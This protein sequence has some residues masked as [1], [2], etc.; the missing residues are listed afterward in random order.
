[1][2]SSE[3]GD[4]VSGFMQFTEFVDFFSFLLFF[5]DGTAVER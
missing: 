2:G 5:L 1:M 3:L 4:E